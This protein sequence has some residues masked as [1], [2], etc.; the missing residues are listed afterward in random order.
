MKTYW[1]ESTLTGGPASRHGKSEV[2]FSGSLTSTF[3]DDSRNS[4]SDQPISFDGMILVESVNHDR[5][6][7]LRILVYL[8]IYHPS[9]VSLEHNLLSWFSFQSQPTLGLS[10]SANHAGLTC[11][12][13]VDH[14]SE[15]SKSTKKK[16]EEEKEKKVDL[17]RTTLRQALALPLSSAGSN[18]FAETCSGSEESPYLRLVGSSITQF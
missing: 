13:R 12:Q 7:F 9:W 11:S 14:F 2:P 1:S 8:V 15:G 10:Q 3:V 5:E 16:K 4:L 18:F 6:C 17:S